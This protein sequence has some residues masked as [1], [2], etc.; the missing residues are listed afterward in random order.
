M[1]VNVVTDMSVTDISIGG[2]G[3]VTTVSVLHTIMSYH[4]HPNMLYICVYIGDVLFCTVLVLSGAC[5]I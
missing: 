2:N 5:I 3:R 1:L 4:E